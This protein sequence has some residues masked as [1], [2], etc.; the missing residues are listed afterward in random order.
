MSETSYSSQEDKEPVKDSYYVLT[1]PVLIRV[2]ET[3]D[4]GELSQA[5]ENAVKDLGVDPDTALS[6]DMILVIKGQ[7]MNLQM[8]QPVIEVTNDPPAG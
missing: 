2:K 4:I 1:S 5:I 3:L 7:K 8:S 6:E